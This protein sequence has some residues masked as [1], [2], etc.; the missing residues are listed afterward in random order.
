[1]F[2]PPCLCYNKLIRKRRQCTKPQFYPI[3]LFPCTFLTSLN[4][5]LLLFK[6]LFQ[7]TIPDS[8]ILRSGYI[9]AFSV[10]IK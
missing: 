4:E 1:M 9:S 6:L 3:D 2:H 10:F 8:K 7:V 5:E